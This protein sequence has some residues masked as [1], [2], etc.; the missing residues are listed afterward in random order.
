MQFCRVVHFC[1]LVTIIIFV[2]FCFVEALPVVTRWVPWNIRAPW[3]W[4]L[5]GQV[6]RTKVI[7]DLAYLTSGCHAVMYDSEL[8][9]HIHTALSPSIA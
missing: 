8:V 4:P 7:T 5:P 6:I 1:G 2:L 9:I 3:Y